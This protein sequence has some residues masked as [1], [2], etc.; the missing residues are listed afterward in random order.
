MV[1]LGSI[2]VDANP[3]VEDIGGI[4]SEEFGRVESSGTL[5]L[6]ENRRLIMVVFRTYTLIDHMVRVRSLLWSY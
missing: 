2:T 5:H 4:L 3:S 1:D 6:Q